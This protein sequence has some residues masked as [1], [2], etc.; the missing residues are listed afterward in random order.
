MSLS[1]VWASPNPGSQPP[2]PLFYLKLVRGP[3]VT[4]DWNMINTETVTRSQGHNK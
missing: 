2:V 3:A 4:G 1:A